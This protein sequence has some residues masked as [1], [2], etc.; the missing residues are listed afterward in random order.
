MLVL[1]T[2]VYS[3]GKGTAIKIYQN[4][5]FPESESLN[6]PIESNTVYLSRPEDNQLQN[7]R[8]ENPKSYTDVS[9]ADRFGRQ[10]QYIFRNL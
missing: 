7:H 9:C 3:I 2:G 8:R 6:R 5:I 10:V 1:P 4:P